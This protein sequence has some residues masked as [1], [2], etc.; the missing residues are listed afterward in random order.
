MAKRKSKK[1]KGR[2]QQVSDGLSIT[3]QKLI[4]CGGLPLFMKVS[5]A[6][7]LK[8][9]ADDLFEL[10]GSNRGYRNG[11]ILKTLV[12][13]LGE[14]V[15]CLNDMRYLHNATELLKRA[16]MKKLASINTLSRWLRHQGKAAWVSL[17]SSIKRRFPPPWRASK[18][19]R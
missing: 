2:R 13:M 9:R 19:R 12:V 10:R 16:R 6:L 1:K 15:R 7:K 14:G 17:I 3:D 5:E 11:D 4:S 18:S 8:Q